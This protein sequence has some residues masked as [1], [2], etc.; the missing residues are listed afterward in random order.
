MIV[1]AVSL[2]AFVWHERKTPS[3]MLPLSLFTVRNFSVGNIATVAI[4]GALSIA[5]FMVIV[6]IQQTGGYS[7]IAAGMAFLPVTIIMFLLSSRFGAL[8][9]KYG[10]RLFMGLGPI[11][12]ALGFLSFLLIDSSVDYWTQVLPGILLFGLGLSL[13]VAPLTAAIL[14]AISPR[15]AGIGSAVNNAVAR[16]AGLLGIAAIGL[17]T[18]PSLDLPGFQRGVVAMAALLAVGGVISAIG[19]QNP[20][21]DDSP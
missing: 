20:K 3:P 16:I 12:A 17:V 2:L 10:P 7:A 15:Q 9:G 5:T 19:I 4:Y 13:T 6:F 8:A 14:G 11:V 1:G 18:G 21:S